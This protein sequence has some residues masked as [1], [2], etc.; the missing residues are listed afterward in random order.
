MRGATECAPRLKRL[1]ASLRSKLGKVHHPQIGD[2]ITQL[3]LGVFSR[4]APE[5]K[6]RE[7]LQQ[8]RAMVVD[9]NELRVVAPIELAEALG[10]S[11]EVRLKCEDLSRALNRV[12]AVEHIVSLDQLEKMPRKDVLD[13]LERIDGLEPYTRARIRLQG[14]R[15][16]AIP[17]NEAAWAYARAARIVNERCGLEEAQSFLERQIAEEDALEFVALIH[18]QG[19]AEM[20]A[21]VRRGETERIRSV[22]PDRTSRNMLQLVV[23]FSGEG[24]APDQ[25]LGSTSERNSAAETQPDGNAAAAKR[26]PAKPRPLAKTR[27]GLARK[28]AAPAAKKRPTRAKPKTKTTTKARPAQTAKKEQP[29]AETARKRK[30]SAARRREARKP[31]AKVKSA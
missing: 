5:A 3:V 15:L 19:W 7:A 9:Y 29:A 28:P 2:P 18:K 24:L 1:F 27:R 16:H 8:L 13:Y 6:A 26:K 11:P 14:L 12:F 22:P 25:P 17:L 31:P 20:G 21:K 30:G 4:D 23:P 10:A